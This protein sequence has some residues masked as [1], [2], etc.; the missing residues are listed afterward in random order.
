MRK[1]FIIALLAIFLIP[2]LLYGVWLQFPT[3]RNPELVSEA[4]AVTN[5][6]IADLN[7]Q[8]EDPETQD[9]RPCVYLC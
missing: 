1:S 5:E 7:M 9:S 6:R 3:A 8:A 2:I 4:Y